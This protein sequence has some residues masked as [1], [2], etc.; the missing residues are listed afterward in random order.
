MSGIPSDV[1]AAASRYGGLVNSIAARYRNPVTGKALSGEALLL[2]LSKGEN[3]FRMGGA[4]SSAGARGAAQFTP[5]SRQVAIKK[6]GIDP[7]HSADEALHAAALHLLGKINGSTGLEGYNP[8]MAS[9]PSYILNQKIGSTGGAHGTGGAVAAVG[10][11]AAHPMSFDATNQQASAEGQAA[12][13]ALAAQFSSPQKKFV[14]QGNPLAGTVFAG[15]APG[16]F[17]VPAAG[18]NPGGAAPKQDIGEVLNT[19]LSDM[20]DTSSLTQPSQSSQ[21]QPKSLVQPRTPGKVVVAAGAENPGHGLQKPLLAFLHDVSSV[22]HQPITVTTGTNHNRLTGRGNVSDHFAGNAADLGVGADARSSSAAGRKGDLIAAH[23]IQ[24]ASGL[25]FKKAFA[26][27][28][29]GGYH[30]FETKAG[31]VQIIWRVDDADGNHF[32][33][34]H[35]GLNPNR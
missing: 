8:G 5:G 22:S 31:R 35:V 12:A 28:R 25:S 11:Q 2:K 32:N 10:G 19:M 18:G 15:Q 7:W 29:Q 14:A 17:A 13:A 33:H 26:L 34:V 24:V 21:S 23:A 4:P 9:Y 3:G 27:A 16:S 20:P 6:F 1:L 30:N